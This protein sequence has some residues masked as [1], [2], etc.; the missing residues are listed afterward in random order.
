[1]DIIIQPFLDVVNDI[2]YIII[3]RHRPVMWIIFVGIRVLELMDIGSKIDISWTIIIFRFLV[4][5][6]SVDASDGLH[7]ALGC[8]RSYHK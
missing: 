6:N 5:L 8:I 7:Y 4:L 2:L 3:S 1:M